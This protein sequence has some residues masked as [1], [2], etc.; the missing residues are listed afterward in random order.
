MSWQ[1]EG[2]GRLARLER[3]DEFESDW[4]SSE[5]ED[6]VLEEVLEDEVLEDEVLAEVLEDEELPMD[7]QPPV[8]MV[9]PVPMD[10]QPQA[11]LA[12]EVSDKAEAV[13]WRAGLSIFMRFWLLPETYVDPNLS[14][15]DR[16]KL[17]EIYG[18]DED[19]PEDD[20][21]DDH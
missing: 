20:P 9:P 19:E 10:V 14:E 8:P 21:E 18:S 4:S 2:R 12:W 17:A 1:R 3:E 16:K 6:E 15:L 13:R 5:D 7:V 11:E